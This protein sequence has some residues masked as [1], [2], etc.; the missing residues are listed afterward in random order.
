M[1]GRKQHYIPQCLLKGFSAER[2]GNKVQVWVFKAGQAPYLTNTVNVAAERHFYSELPSGDQEITLDDLITNYEKS[3]AKVLQQFRD[4]ATNESVDCVLAAEFVTHL[5]IRGDFLRN[6]FG[7][8][9]QEIITTTST[10]VSEPESLRSMIGLDDNQSN[11]E[12]F[13]ELSENLRILRQNLSCEIPETLLQRIALFYSREEFETIYAQRLSWLPDALNVFGSKIPTLARGSHIQ[14]LEKSLAPQP[15]IETLTQLNWTVI[16]VPDAN[17]IL[18]DCVAISVGVSENRWIPHVLG[19]EV[20]NIEQVL[21]PI[22]TN[23]LL[24]GRRD[25]NRRVEFEKFNRF[26]AAC[27]A[28]FFVSPINTAAIASYVADIGKESKQN[29]LSIA[30]NSVEQLGKT[31]CL[32]STIEIPG[33][34]KVT[35]ANIQDKTGISFP[36]SFP[37]SVDRESAEKIAS[38]IEAIVCELAKIMPLNRIESVVFTANCPEIIQTI[39]KRFLISQL[40]EPIEE[41]H[42]VGLATAHVMIIDEKVMSSI[43]SSSWL[44]QALLNPENEDLFQTA[45]HVL[46]TLLAGISFI[47]L[48]DTTLPDS[49]IKPLEDRWS[50][51][52]FKHIYNACSSYFCARTSAGCKP[53]KEDWYRDQV[54]IAFRHAKEVI[55]NAR[56]SY[57]HDGDLDSFLEFAIKNIGDALS[58]AASLIGHCDG[59]GKSF[60]GDEE[61]VTKILDEL[62]L[63]KWIYVYQRDLEKIFSKQGKWTDISELTALNI[64]VERLLWQFSVF[65]WLMDTGQIKVEIPLA[66]D[67]EDLQ[68]TA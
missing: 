56:L 16:K 17:L 52:L 36:V 29:I 58:C 53:N 10:L 27:S 50:G 9:F 23:Q 30:R 18:P 37:D 15:R 1:S 68:K 60:F 20:E 5:T 64:H 65:P 21:L 7:L 59:L 14:A 31:S 55:P 39:D 38:V 6:V 61:Q 67:M 13:K 28:E 48:V 22:S 44:G 62:G 33:E 46:V 19:S 63:K 66:V 40:L 24:V 3:L 26:A 12:F 45:L 2:R 4:L 43:I 41:E 8:G 25:L 11:S 49:L 35:S 54:I 51:I 47:E 34:I 32:E 42:S 57:R